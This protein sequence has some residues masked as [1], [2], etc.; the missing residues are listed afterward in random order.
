MTF[1]IIT[2]PNTLDNT[3][4][5]DIFVT[6]SNERYETKIAFLKGTIRDNCVLFH[7]LFNKYYGPHL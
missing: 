5:D 7:L 6:V 1:H 2:T 3:Q 4:F